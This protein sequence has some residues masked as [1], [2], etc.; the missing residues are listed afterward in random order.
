[1]QRVIP[2]VPPPDGKLRFSTPVTRCTAGVAPSF[3]A[4]A[5]FRRSSPV[6]A[7]WLLPLASFQARCGFGR[8]Q[9]RDGDG[10]MP[11]GGAEARKRRLGRIAHGAV[12]A[13]TLR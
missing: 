7:Q 5:A 6:R 4:L 9:G 13:E 10:P 3:A 8:T 1:M 11:R 12:A 2:P